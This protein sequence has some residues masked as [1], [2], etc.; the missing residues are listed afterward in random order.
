VR[1]LSRRG[2]GAIGGLTPGTTDA[3]AARRKAEQRAWGALL[4]LCGALF[5]D[6][7]DVSMTGVALPTIRS[8]LDISTSSLQWIVGAGLVARGPQPAYVGHPTARL[9]SAHAGSSLGTGGAEAPVR[10]WV[11]GAGAHG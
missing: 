9:N 10:G 8:D 2:G 7:L 1:A 5:L 6:A 4:V 3:A 11:Q